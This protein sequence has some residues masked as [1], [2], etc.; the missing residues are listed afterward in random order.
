MQRIRTFRE[1]PKATPEKQISET[2]ADACSMIS[3]A[4]GTGVA[5]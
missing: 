5:G 1:Q 3:Q 4:N 2:D